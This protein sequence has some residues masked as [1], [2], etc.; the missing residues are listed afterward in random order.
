MTAKVS[1]K[2]QVMQNKAVRYLL[3]LPPRT[4]ISRED[5]KMA[6]MLP[7]HLRVEQLK[8]SHMYNIIHSTAPSYL[9]TQ[10][11]MVHSQ[12]HHNTRASVNSCSVPK[13]NS[14]AQSSF[15]YTGIALWNELPPSVRLIN[16]KEAYK[17]KVR[18]HLFD[19]VQ[20]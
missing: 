3:N 13:V 11:V 10:I 2:L 9:N 12:H 6:G 19:K 4:H 15:F 18:N 17:S 7:V 16:R 1:G 14:V 8:L 5:F 20:D